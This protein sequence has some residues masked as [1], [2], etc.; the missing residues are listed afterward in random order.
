MKILLELSVF[1]QYC[2]VASGAFA[3]SALALAFNLF[4]ARLRGRHC[5]QSVTFYTTVFFAFCGACAVCAV[6]FRE[7]VYCVPLCFVRVCRSHKLIRVR[8][9]VLVVFCARAGQML[10]LSPARTFILPLE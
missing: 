3:V 7:L 1:I 5:V 8:L 2:R 6:V 9:V 10:R 4:L